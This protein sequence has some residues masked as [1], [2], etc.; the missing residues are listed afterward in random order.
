MEDRSVLTLHT[1]IYCLR[2]KCKRNTVQTSSIS[3]NS[4][5]WLISITNTNTWTGKGHILLQSSSR[6]GSHFVEISR[7]ADRWSYWY[8]MMSE[9]IT[10]PTC[11]TGFKSQSSLFT[12]SLDL[13]CIVGIEIRARHPICGAL[14]H[15]TLLIKTDTEYRRVPW[16]GAHTHTPADT[17]TSM[18]EQHGWGSECGRCFS[19]NMRKTRQF[20]SDNTFCALCLD[21][22]IITVQAGS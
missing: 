20:N 10:V 14:W 18:A 9:V 2:L 19:A 22:V 4:Y 15:L 16:Q 7:E 8:D 17:H 12:K 5:V 21:T 11:S 1:N 13:T 3:K 6:K